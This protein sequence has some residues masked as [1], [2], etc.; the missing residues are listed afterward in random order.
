VTTIG[1][2]F[3]TL[4]RRVVMA[5]AG[6]LPLFYYG[7]KKQGVEKI[8]PKGLGFGLDD[9][10]IFATELE[11]K[12][13]QYEA[14][15]VFLFVTDGITEAHSSRGEEFGEE[16][17]V[18]ILENSAGLSAAQIRDHVITAVKRFGAGTQQHDDQTV[19]VVKV[20]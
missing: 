7:A 15:D 9:E 4:S 17:I 2:D 3:D 10:G 14:G 11:E 20:R 5:R 19:V 18:R 16:S 8:T 6:H 1:A 12:T 13:M